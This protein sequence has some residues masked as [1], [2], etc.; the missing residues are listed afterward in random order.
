M[1]LL[2]LHVYDATPMISS[3][4]PL[5]SPLYQGDT[6]LVT[7]V[8]QDFG[9]FGTGSSLTFTPSAGS[10]GSAGD[11]T[12]ATTG[13]NF[14]WT[15][16]SITV[17]VTASS[18]A[19]G[20]YDVFVTSAGI[21][22]TGFVPSPQ[23][24]GSQSLSAKGPGGVAAA[25]A[26]MK[27]EQVGDILISTDGN[28]SEDTTI[29]VTAV[30]PDGSTITGFGGTVV[31]AED[32]TAIYSQNGG[33][34]CYLSATQENCPADP[35]GGKQVVIA[36]GQNGTATFLAQSLAGSPDSEN[37]PDPAHIKTSNFTMYG[38]P[39]RCSSG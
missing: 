35:S 6:V 33:T 1:L 8:G 14:S 17:P 27:L 15:P 23:P 30:R 26:L 10:C 12:Y 2:N 34:L 37:P 4:T 9:K 13:P 24:G 32:G 21:S 19:C 38:V 3:V 28:Y 18:S 31:V 11:L 7:L 5:V 20:N 16:G 29:R 25:P 36:Q 39:S 22:G